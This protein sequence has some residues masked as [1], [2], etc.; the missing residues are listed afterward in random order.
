MYIHYLAMAG[1]IDELK[2]HLHDNPLLLN[3]KSKESGSSLLIVAVYSGQLEIAKFLLTFPDI[4]IYAKDQNGRNV[5]HFLL[6]GVSEVKVEKRRAYYDI[7]ETI[8]QLD[9]LHRAHSSMETILLETRDLRGCTPLL[10]IGLSE[11]EAI[12]STILDIAK[13]AE[14]RAQAELRE[15]E[16][17]EEMARLELYSERSPSILREKNQEKKFGRWWSFS[18]FLSTCGFLGKKRVEDP[19]LLESERESLLK[20][21]MQ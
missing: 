8:L 15:R 14:E 18:S 9:A 16:I 2:Q 20:K 1:K 21:K 6:L 3:A 5:L 10:L 17:Q 11:D 12:K 19:T 4:N 13:K 7:A